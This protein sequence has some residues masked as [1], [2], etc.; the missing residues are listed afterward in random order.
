MR[1][2]IVLLFHLDS[3]FKQDNLKA[4]LPD[5][6]SQ[7]PRHFGINCSVKLSCIYSVGQEARTKSSKCFIDEDLSVSDGQHVIQNAIWRP[8]AIPSYKLTDTMLNCI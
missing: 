2:G 3:T 4:R 5:F 6:D 7:E 8:K 1:T